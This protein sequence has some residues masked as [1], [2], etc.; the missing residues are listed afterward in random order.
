MRA[1]V[2]ERPGSALLTDV[3]DPTP[4]PGEVLMQVE[5]AGL[6]GTDVHSYRDEYP[7]PF[8]YIP[9]H[10]N[11]GTVVG[12]GAGVD[13]AMIGRRY[14]VHPLLPCGTCD[15]CR[16]GRINY[17]ATLQVYGF[18][19]GGGFAEL[20]AVNTS[21]LVE[22]PASVPA[23]VAAFAEPLACVL[24]GLEKVRV[25]GGDR[26][27]L[28]GAGPI[29]LLILQACRA[30]GAAQVDVV[31][32][33]PEKMTTAQRVG[34]HPCSSDLLVPEAYDLVID[35]TGV[36][37]VVEGLTSYVRNAGRVLYF[38]VCPPDARVQL[39]PYE[40][41]R[42][43]LTIVGCF[44]LAREFPAAVQMLVDGRVD[45]KPLI[46]DRLPLSAMEEALKGHGKT[47]AGIKTLFIPSMG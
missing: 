9:G 35:A 47:S 11:A 13:A 41:F 26:V 8:P 40:I 3:P 1:I 43:E 34:G 25:E 15:A 19:L 20:M 10:E 24:H 12:V 33:V 29:G 4:G 7:S 27:L 42:R 18:G 22:V 46:T 5:A 44:S 36:A 31:E 6:C 37:R 39:S 14:A 21:C 45:V 17:C 23:D 2:F 30:L 16:V 28:F 32:I 38:G